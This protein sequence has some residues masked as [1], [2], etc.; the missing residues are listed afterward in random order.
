[1][2]LVYVALGALFTV[3]TLGLIAGA[4]ALLQRP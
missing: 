3:L 2:D 1:M 4:A